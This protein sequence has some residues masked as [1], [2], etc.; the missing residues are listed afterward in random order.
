MRLESLKKEKLKL[1]LNLGN[2]IAGRNK[3]VDGTTRPS[4]D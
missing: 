3:P 4:T 1:K 2:V